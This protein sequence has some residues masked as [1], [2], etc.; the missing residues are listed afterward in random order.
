M[1]P[2]ITPRGETAETRQRIEAM[3]RGSRRR[4]VNR[5]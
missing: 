4:S 2:T 1:N 3:K 5:E